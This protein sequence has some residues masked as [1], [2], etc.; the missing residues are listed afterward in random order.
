MARKSTPVA[1]AQD[2]P[3]TVAAAPTLEQIRERSLRDCLQV[4][5]DAARTIADLEAWRDEID[6]TIAFLRAQGG[7]RRA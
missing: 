2:R 4:R 7:G 5:A 6:A 3:A 1:P